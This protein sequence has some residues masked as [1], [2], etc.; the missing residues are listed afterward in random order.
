MTNNYPNKNEVIPN[1]DI[2]SVCYVKNLI[3]DERIQIGDYTYFDCVTTKEEFMN[4]LQHFYAFSKDKLIIGKFCQIANGV[5]FIMNAANHR[6]NCATTYPF[7]IMGGKWGS[8]IAPHDDELPNKG[9]IV[10]GNDV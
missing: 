6:M 1:L 10:I 5:K 3:D 2:P 8:A 4:C 9:D 7:Y